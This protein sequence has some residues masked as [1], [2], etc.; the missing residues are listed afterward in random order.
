MAI[1]EHDQTAVG[2]VDPSWTPIL[3][4]EIYCS[5]SCGGKC[6]KPDYDNARQVSNE[7]ATQLGDGWIPKVYENLGWYWKVVK[8]NAEVT[9]TYDKK[10][11]I[12][13]IQFNLDQNY[14]FRANDPNP[15]NAVKKVREQL[16][17]VIRKLEQQYSSLELD[18]ISISTRYSE[19]PQ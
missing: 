14:F 1:Y 17:D 7:V 9:P 4:G 12:A 3:N 5:P 18:P 13:E 6:K 10:S 2:E 15:R 11:Y 19:N 16:V 8:G